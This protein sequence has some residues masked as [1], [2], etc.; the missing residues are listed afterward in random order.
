ME[1]KIVSLNDIAKLS[2]GI[3]LSRDKNPAPESSV[4]S[5][6]D[7]ET[8]LTLG[9]SGQCHEYN[10]TKKENHILKA[11]DIVVNLGTRRCTIVSMGNENKVIKNSFVKIE[12]SSSLIY[13]WFL[14]YAI[15]ESALFKE[16]IATDVL[17]IVRP[18]SVSIL[19]NAQ[20]YLPDTDTQKILG[21]IYRDLC[22]VKAL[23]EKRNKLLMEAF[24]IIITNKMEEK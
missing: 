6:K 11:G 7:H 9:Y 16:S 13:P 21:D 5:S 15:N 22:R 19:G 24:N 8:D 17:S 20:L 14:C 4:Y 23:N 12:P 1:Q 10:Q 18:L 2:A 3:N